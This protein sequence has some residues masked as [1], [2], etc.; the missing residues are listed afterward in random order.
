MKI[1]IDTFKGSRLH[2]VDVSAVARTKWW[3]F[4]DFSWEIDGKRVGTGAIYAVLSLFKEIPI[5]DQIIFCFDF[6]GNIRKIENKDYKA[7]RTTEGLEG[8]FKQ[9]QELHE[10]L[11]ASGFNTVGQT[12]YEADDFMAGAVKEYKNK[13]DHIFLYTN[14]EDLGALIDNNVYFKSIL[15]KKSDVTRGNY[16]K[17]FKIPYN[18]MNLYKATVG[19]SSDEIK[20]V[21]RFGKVK[22]G[23]FINEVSKEYDLTKITEQ[24]L[25]EEVLKNYKGFDDE[26]RDQALQSLRL[27]LPRL[28]NKYHFEDLEYGVDDKLFKWY[29]DRY[30]MKSIID[31]I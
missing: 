10:I 19:C 26:Q 15:R 27:A 14:D 4:K 31:K 24:E 29:L 30:G 16:E 12:G 8:Y 20:G 17:E 1:R 21:H 13:F 5:K 22:F 25:E 7:S 9:I 28:P 11:V 18:T 3:S 23:K 6:G 2:L